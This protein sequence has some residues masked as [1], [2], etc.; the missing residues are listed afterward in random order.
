MIK[1]L[2]FNNETSKYEWVEKGYSLPN[3]KTSKE[4]LSINSY[5]RKHGSIKSPITGEPF[6]TKRSY[7]DHAKANNCVI[8]DW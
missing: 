3:R 8:K 7:L 4:D 2:V 1:K 6:Y 5:I